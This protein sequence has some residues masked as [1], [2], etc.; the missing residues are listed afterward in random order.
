M[1]QDFLWSCLFVVPKLLGD[2]VLQTRAPQNM[3]T[4]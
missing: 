4:V 3:H 2:L 1:R